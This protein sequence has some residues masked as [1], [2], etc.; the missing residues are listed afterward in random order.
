MN[1]NMQCLKKYILLFL[2]QWHIFFLYI[3]VQLILHY[4]P[5]PFK[6]K[7]SLLILCV[8]KCF[9]VGQSVYSLPYAY[10]YATL[11]LSP[12]LSCNLKLTPSVN[13]QYDGM[14]RLTWSELSY[15]VHG[16]VSLGH[17]FKPCHEHL[18]C[19]WTLTQ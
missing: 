10:Y 16:K 5:P 4:L 18:L 15:Q 6:K 14:L 19:Y 17:P 9:N 8:K 7:K 1:E 12:F 13:C 11:S 2:Y 3:H